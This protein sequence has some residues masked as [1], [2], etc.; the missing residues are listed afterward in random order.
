MLSFDG[1][2]SEAFD[3]TFT[4]GD[5]DVFGVTQSYEL[6]PGGNNISVTN[7]NRQVNTTD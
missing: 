7:D 2:V 3:L 4:V 1:D 5:A 6:K